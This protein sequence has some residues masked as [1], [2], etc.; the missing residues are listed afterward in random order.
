MKTSYGRDGASASGALERQLSGWLRGF[1]PGEAPIG[2]RVRISADLRTQTERRR[3]WIP[4]LTNGMSWAVASV[5]ALVGAALVVLAAGAGGAVSMVGSPNSAWPGQTV[6]PPTDVQVSGGLTL[7]WLAALL[8]AAGLVGASTTTTPIRRMGRRLFVTS[9]SVQPARAFPRRIRDIPRLAF[10]L[11][12]LAIFETVWWLY[13]YGIPLTSTDWL[14]TQLLPLGLGPAIAL[15]HWPPADRSAR[16]LLVGAIAV[17]VADLPGLALVTAAQWGWFYIT[18]LGGTLSDMLP[19]VVLSI[20]ALGWLSIG[21]GVAAR[22]GVARLP[23][24]P[25]VAAAVALVLFL[26]MA[27]S[28]NFA[29]IVGAQMPLAPRDTAR[30]AWE[31]VTT[32]VQDL[33]WLAILWTALARTLQRGANQA[34][35]LALVAAVTSMALRLYAPLVSAGW[36][37]FVD[38][39]ALMLLSW[40]GA[41][42]LLM[43]ILI[44]LDPSGNAQADPVEVARQTA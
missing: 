36:L 33:A 14:L 12:L 26:E 16:W 39:Q 3:G 15:R 9:R 22:S 29:A 5:V 11:A 35:M 31:T 42:T 7:P 34:W 17:A 41:A 8:I 43:A 44:G 13:A 19:F 4:R 2:L 28:I 20:T 21:A 37:P 27:G 38:G 40:L 25:V 1:D 32:C 18:D 6:P 23:R 30:I 10:A 24:R